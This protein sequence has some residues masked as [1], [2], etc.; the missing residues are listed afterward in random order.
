[1]NLDETEPDKM[2]PPNREA[3]VE[4]EARSA[5]DTAD[6]AEQRMQ[7]FG[8][9]CL[10]GGISVGVGNIIAALVAAV[11]TENRIIPDTQGGLV[12]AT[13]ALV[14]I[15]ALATAFVT[16]GAAERVLRPNRAAFRNVVAAHEESDKRSARIEEQ[17][18]TIASHLPTA[19]NAE[20]RRGFNEAV[21]EVFAETG[22]ETGGAPRKTRHLNVAPSEQGK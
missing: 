10:Y 16:V 19:L 6:A 9:I 7:R 20:H 12:L 8:R 5:S 13:L 1:M 11:A 18:R 21:I 15:A 22:T 4:R 17:L 3:P 14:T 2:V